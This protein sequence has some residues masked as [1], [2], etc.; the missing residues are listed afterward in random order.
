VDLH[1]VG[2]I[3]LGPLP[4]DVVLETQLKNKNKIKG[5]ITHNNY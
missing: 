3:S 4:L 2:G 5:T 1:D